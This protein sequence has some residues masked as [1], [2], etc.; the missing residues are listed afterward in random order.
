MTTSKR[1]SNRA[2]GGGCGH[3]VA[4]PASQEPR[5]RQERQPLQD[6]GRE[7]E[8][9]TEI[10]PDEGAAA[11]E[12]RGHGEGR[13][14]DRVVRGEAAAEPQHEDQGDAEGERSRK[15]H[16]VRQEGRQHRDR[17]QRD[18]R[19]QR[20]VAVSRSNST[21]GFKA[22]ANRIGHAPGSKPVGGS[23]RRAGPADVSGNVRTPEGRRG[24]PVS[25]RTGCKPQSPPDVGPC[26]RAAGSATGVRRSST[27]R[28]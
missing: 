23:H 3:Q 9:T 10:E 18:H 13:R 2:R 27:P 16:V 25:R 20:Q 19:D 7:E 14:H 24:G 11:S 15:R 22:R 8:A 5:R 12:P 1:R 26:V 4:P 17:V 28:P 6:R 21:C